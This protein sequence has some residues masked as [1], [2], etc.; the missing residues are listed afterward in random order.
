MTVCSLIQHLIKHGAKEVC[1]LCKTADH[2][3]TVVSKRMRTF[4]A[5]KPVVDDA[6]AARVVAVPHQAS[7]LMGK[8]SGAV[9]KVQAL[10]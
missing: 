10:L 7:V 5:I 3:L 1:V 2:V 4:S 9:I 6:C 8:Q